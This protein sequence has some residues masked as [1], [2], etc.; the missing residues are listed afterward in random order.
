[1]SRI[2]LIDELPDDREL[3]TSGLGMLGFTVDAVA[4]AEAAAG[5]RTHPPDVIVLHLAHGDRWDLCDELQTL[6]GSIPVVVLTAAVRPDGSNRERA[7]AT[8]NCAAF[9]GKPCT[10]EDLGAIIGRVLSGERRLEFVSGRET[11]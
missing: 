8:A 11:S 10:H 7:R 6:Y 5:P 1:M 2:L 3:Y 9:V 4:T